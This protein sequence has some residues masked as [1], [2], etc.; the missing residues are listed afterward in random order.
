MRSAGE[1]EREVVR[2]PAGLFVAAAVGA[3]SSDAAVEFYE[4]DW[5]DHHAPRA[6]A[7]DIVF[8]VAVGNGGSDG[9][10]DDNDASRTT[11]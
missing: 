9:V 1:G 3:L 8:V 2:L 11:Y 6:N 7:A 5:G 4:L 10:G